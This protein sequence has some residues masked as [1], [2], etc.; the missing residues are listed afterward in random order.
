MRKFLLRTALAIAVFSMVGAAVPASFAKAETANDLVIDPQGS[1]LVR[2][3][4]YCQDV[5]S[6]IAPFLTPKFL[7]FVE[8][9]DDD[10]GKLFRLVLALGMREVTFMHT[11]KDFLVSVELPKGKLEKLG[12]G[13][14]SDESIGEA[15]GPE[16]AAVFI[17]ELS[18]SGTLPDVKKNVQPGVHEVDGLF[19]GV[20]GQTM[21]VGSSDVQV[22]VSRKKLLE[23]KRIAAMPEKKQQAWYKA[24]VQ[25][26]CASSDQ[27]EFSPRTYTQESVYFKTEDGW[28]QTTT[29]NFVEFL[30]FAEQQ[31]V[32][33]LKDLPMYG[34]ERPF[35]SMVYGGGILEAL[36]RVGVKGEFPPL[37]TF[38]DGTPFSARDIRQFGCFIGGPRAHVFGFPVPGAMALID[39]TEELATMVEELAANTVPTVWREKTVGGWDR[40]R[41]ADMVNAEGTPIPMPLVLGRKGGL[42]MFGL[43]SHDQLDSPKDGSI[44]QA[45]VPAGETICGFAEFDFKSFW[46]HARALMGKESPLRALAGVARP[47][48]AGNMEAVDSLLET[49]LP[50]NRA[51][52]WA[53][54]DLSVSEAVLYEN[55]E[56]TLFWDRFCD[57]MA[58]AAESGTLNDR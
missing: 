29:T 41:V 18:R 27:G 5:N 48:I 38:L 20:A 56:P 37:R 36:T 43:M 53:R 34:E 26:S 19:M 47:E 15:M 6:I 23:G 2:Q 10:V 30:P 22:E 13:D 24:D 44:L 52:Q 31:A 40:L 42:L 45:Q 57:I 58:L 3:G 33:R 51:S 14:L 16:G 55:K 12:E 25:V 39:T 49:E 4:I 35:L 46:G 54:S 7:A 11:S 28:T 8:K 17:K 50:I 1:A 32:V 9:Q 21:L